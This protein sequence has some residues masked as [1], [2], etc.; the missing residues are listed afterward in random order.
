MRRLRLFRSLQERDRRERVLDETL[1]KF[2]ERY[3]MQGRRNSQDYQALQDLLKEDGIKLSVERLKALVD[4]KTKELFYNRLKEALS[5]AQTRESALEALVESGLTDKLEET[6]SFYAPLILDY[7]K[8]RQL[9][10]WFMNEN[11]L[12]RELEKAKERLIR[13]N[14]KETLKEVLEGGSIPQSIE[15]IDKMEGHEFEDFLEHLF[16]KMGFQVE[17]PPLARDKGADLIA[18]R[19]G[20]KIAIQAKCYSGSVGIK[21]VQEV[22][23]AKDFYECDRSMVVTNSYFTQDAQTLA[24]TIKVE[25][26][27]R[28]KLAQVLRE[29]PIS[30]PKA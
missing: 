12:L 3:I 7:L 4:Q 24:E 17:R 21:A 27:N 26:W 10:G 25:L 2:V 20:E 28:D 9:K 8:N 5:T 29:Y 19:L 16:K 30:F 6:W 11:R 18:A 23:A 15:D 22:S 13:R 1:T 14:R